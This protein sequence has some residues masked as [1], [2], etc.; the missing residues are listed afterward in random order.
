MV[1]E[2]SFRRTNLHWSATEF[3]RLLRA[4]KLED[5]TPPAARFD[6]IAA[7]LERTP[8]SVR[9]K[10]L[11]VRDAGLRGKQASSPA[12]AAYV[13]QRFP[14]ARSEPAGDQ[15]LDALIAAYR[16][17]QRRADALLERV[18]SVAAR[19][20]EQLAGLRQA[21]LAIP[22]QPALV[23]SDGPVVEARPAA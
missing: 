4:V 12:V 20:G 6:A 17:A 9:G 8:A 22:R 18:F 21:L 2:P 15:S 7:S 3:D 13:K 1:K 14:D 23:A 19:D 5:V 16:E 11:E 10:W